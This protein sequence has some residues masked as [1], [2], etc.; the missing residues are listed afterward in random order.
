MY[1]REEILSDGYTLDIIM[2]HSE[3]D[4]ERVG[5]FNFKH[6]EG[7][8]KKSDKE[9]K[10]FKTLENK[11]WKGYPE[12]SLG[13]SLK[14]VEKLKKAGK[15][16][17]KHQNIIWEYQEI[18]RKLKSDPNTNNYTEEYLRKLFLRAGEIEKYLVAND[19]QDEL[20]C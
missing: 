3:F 8:Y 17:M 1:I 7:Y 10:S 20:I 2:V 4:T 11:I 6:N 13:V 14:T 15:E 9:I 16:A 5:R 19:M 12:L 18:A